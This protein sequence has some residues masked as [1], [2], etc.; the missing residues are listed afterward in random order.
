LIPDAAVVKRVLDGD[1]EAYAVLVERYQRSAHSVALGILGDFQAAEDATQDAL[2][3]AF[4]KLGNLRKPERFGPWLVQIVRR[5]ALDS[6]RR[7]WATSPLE[8]A[9]EVAADPVD[10]A[11]GESSQ[12]LL[13]EV[14]RLPERE[15]Q[16]VILRHFD[17]LSVKDIAMHLSQAVGTVTKTLSRAHGR[18]RGRLRE[19]E[20]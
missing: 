9:G 12:R 15:K 16:V 10:P 4:E 13:A 7:R 5:K 14:L 6:V 17:G 1:R 20:P 2:V 19:L 8:Q 11:L 18:L 3:S